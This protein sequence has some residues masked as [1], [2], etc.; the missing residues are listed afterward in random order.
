MKRV[1]ALVVVVLLVGIVPLLSSA[2]EIG[3][4]ETGFGIGFSSEPFDIAGGGFFLD[5]IGDILLWDTFAT[6][7][8]CPIFS[9]GPFGPLPP[10]VSRFILD[11]MVVA[12]FPL[13]RFTLF[14]GAGMGAIFTERWREVYTGWVSAAGA[15]V[16][17]NEGL[18]LFAQV[19]MRGIGFLSPGAGF[20][21]SF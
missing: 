15:T 17:I 20:R 2:Q 18:T 19:R 16:A 12:E 3:P 4:G 13:E 1:I 6:F 21:L 14:A 11:I 8:L 9:I 5:I 10:R 7:H